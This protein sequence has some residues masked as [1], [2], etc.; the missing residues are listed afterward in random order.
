M[1]SSPTNALYPMFDSNHK[2][3]IKNDKIMRRRIELSTYTFD[4]FYRCRAENIPINTLSKIRFMSLTVDKLY[5]LHEALGHPRVTRMLHFVISKNLPFF[6]DGIK[7]M[8]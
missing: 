7:S 4:I 1:L 3:K 8:V 6:V 5:K 2:R